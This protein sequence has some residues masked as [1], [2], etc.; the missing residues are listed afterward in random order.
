MQM[1]HL[2]LQVNKSAPNGDGS[3]IF[4]GA[5]PY[6]CRPKRRLGLHRR[7]ARCVRL[8]RQPRPSN[9]STASAN[10]RTRWRTC[11]R[12]SPEARLPRGGSGETKCRA[13]GYGDRFPRQ[14][15]RQPGGA[16]NWVAGKGGELGGRMRLRSDHKLA[17]VRDMDVATRLRGAREV[18]GSLTRIVG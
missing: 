11:C 10:C 12:W 15:L 2:A 6:A 18:L 3:R 5:F 8:E 14:R 7:I 13:E 4:A 17:I 9:S 16:V 1:R